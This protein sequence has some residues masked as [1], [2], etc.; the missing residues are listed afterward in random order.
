MS[1]LQISGLCVLPLA[2]RIEEWLA[3]GKLVEEDLERTLGQDG[4]ALVE[5]GLTADD[6]VPVELVES[7]VALVAEQVGGETG[8]AE[9]AAEI[10]SDWLEEESTKRWTESSWRLVD[11]PGY[12]LACAAERILGPGCWEYEGGRARFALRLPGTESTSAELKT[13]I[14]ALLARLAGR[15][16]DRDLGVR[17][18]AIDTGTLVLCADPGA[19]ATLDPIRERRLY[20][21]ALAPVADPG[22]ESDPASPPQA[23]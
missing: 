12:F 5:H 10:A 2:L 20:R 18:T 11:G 21:A 7:L 6:R 4:R 22:A 13:L 16:L 14:G 17:S 1:A 23:T 19:V 9:L 8:L 15:A 3:E